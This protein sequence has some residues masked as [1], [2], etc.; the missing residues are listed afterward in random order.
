MLTLVSRHCLQE[1]TVNS[2]VA[3]DT[4]L[5]GGGGTDSISGHQSTPNSTRRHASQL[6]QESQHRPSCILLTGPNYSGKSIYL[7]QVSLS[8]SAPS[9]WPT[10]SPMSKQVALIVYLAH[11]GWSVISKVLAL[12][13]ILM[14]MQLRTGREGRDWLDR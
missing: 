1:L 4:F 3:N 6:S 13:T 2:Y 5:I 12:S 9:S 11:I 7:K 8:R 10:N 14:L